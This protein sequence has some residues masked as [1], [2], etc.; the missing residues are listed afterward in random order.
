MSELEHSGP[1]GPSGQPKSYLYYGPP[2]S[3]KTTFAAYLER[4]GKLLK[5]FW[6]DVDNKLREMEN[7]P[8][9][10]RAAI[11]IWACDEQL[12]D[13]E[14][15]QIPSAPNPK[16]PHKGTLIEREPRGI[17][18]TVDCINELL[19][20]ARACRRDSKPFPYDVVVLDSLTS[21]SEHTIRK[22]MFDQR[23]AFMSERNW[24]L[25]T[26][27]ML[28]L[29][30]GFLQLPCERVVIAHSRTYQI[31]DRET[32]TVMDEYIRPHIV[33][34]LA[35]TI[36]KDFSE[37]YFFHG[38]ERSGQYKIQ[39]VKDRLLVART[40]RDIPPEIFIDPKTKQMILGKP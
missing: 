26:Q 31:R 22:V 20:L 14:R 11:T 28:E 29:Y 36:A 32:D 27:T 17:R 38:R 8:P 13:P 5:K 34:Q 15:I 7:L 6:V 33:G 35:E 12:G 19:S 24:G 37:V 25:V 21:C 16:D 18:R 9:D 10:V 40:T 4:E 1:L 30:R 3:G 39:T 2:G 23:I